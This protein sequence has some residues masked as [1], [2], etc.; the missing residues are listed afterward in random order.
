MEIRELVA[1]RSGYIALSSRSKQQR[2]RLSQQDQYESG[3]TPQTIREHHETRGAAALPRKNAPLMANEEQE[4][5]TALYDK[6][7]TDGLPNNSIVQVLNDQT[8]DDW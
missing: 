4:R 6:I 1:I 8:D 7:R 5:L 3:R 2:K